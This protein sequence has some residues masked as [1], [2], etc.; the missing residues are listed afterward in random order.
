[1][2]QKILQ[3]S[4]LFILISACEKK[5]DRHNLILY[6]KPLSVIQS[7]IQGN[8]KVEYEKGGFCGR[9][10]WNIS[11]FYWYFGPGDVVKQTYRDTLI[12]DGSIIWE[13]GKPYNFDETYIMN[14]SDE[15]GYPYLYVVYELKNDTL[16]LADAGS[17]P[18]FYYLTK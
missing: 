2:F 6:D 5:Y 13:W 18:M 3:V 16:I 17:D 1:M 12:T 8:W 10:V 7:C 11:D 14:F 4:F 15:R 9:C